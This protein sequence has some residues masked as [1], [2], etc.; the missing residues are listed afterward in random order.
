[1][2]SIMQGQ[3]E[4]FGNWAFKDGDVVSGCAVTD[5]PQ[6][7]YVRMQDA[8]TNG[9]G[10]S[11][12][13][14][15]NTRLVSTSSNLQARV[16]LGTQGLGTNYPNTNVL[17]ITY[18]NTGTSNQQIFSPNETINVYSIATGS[19]VAV[20]NTF[21]NTANATVTVTGYA[22]G[23][24]VGEG[25]VYLNGNFI[26]VLAPTY[27][28]VNAYGTAAGNNFVGFQLTETIITE[29][30]DPSLLDNALGYPNENA[31]ARIEECAPLA[32]GRAL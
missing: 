22:H 6:I 30:Q 9:A 3:I 2:Q 26:K 27:G 31:P 18:N 13:L 10:F 20:V 4:N 1:M 25:V 17:Y 11:P 32:R 29:N 23:I 8:Q 5:Q 28:I 7:P 16:I 15:A 12:T 14:L 21:S 19:L 24:S